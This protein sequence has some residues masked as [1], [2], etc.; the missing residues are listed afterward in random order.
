MCRDE[1]GDD[2][3]E[4]IEQQLAEQEE[5][6]PEKIIEESRRR[7]LAILE[8]YKQKQ[9]QLEQQLEVPLF[10]DHGKGGFDRFNRNHSLCSIFFV[11]NAPEI[12]ILVS[13]LLILRGEDTDS[14]VFC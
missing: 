11:A 4:K 3:E 9:V 2:Y 5:D 6:D 13:F 8:K 14:S 1:Q 12:V 7:R 10:E